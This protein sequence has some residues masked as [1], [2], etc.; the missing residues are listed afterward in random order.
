MYHAALERAAGERRAFLEGGVCRK[1]GPANERWRPCSG[2]RTP[3]GHFIEAPRAAGGCRRASVRA[4]CLT[5]RHIG[6]YTVAGADRRWRDGRGLSRPR[7]EARPRR[8]DQSPASSVHWPIRTRRARFEREAR[9]LA[10]LN[11]PTHRAD[12]RSSRKS[13]GAP[14]AG[15]RTGATGETLAESVNGARHRRTA[16]PRCLSWT[17]RWPIARQIA[18][19]LEAAHEK[20]IV[21]R[22]L[23]PANIKV[24]PDGVVK[25]LDFG[26]AK[27]L[28]GRSGRRRA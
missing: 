26:L 22:D 9:L 7:H 15:P 28:D 23:K 3:P 18:D 20:G 21:H 4:P 12:L 10:T 24:T 19:A 14:R 17:S 27:A 1:R 2:T 11:H 8:G 16:G 13:D 25:V 6:S 5:G